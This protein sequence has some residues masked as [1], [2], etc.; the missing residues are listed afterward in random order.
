[1]SCQ[2]IISVLHLLP[3]VL[4]INHAVILTNIRMKSIEMKATVLLI[5]LLGVWAAAALPVDK[6][7]SIGGPVEEFLCDLCYWFFGEIEKLVE[8]GHT[9]AEL[10]TYLHEVSTNTKTGTH[11]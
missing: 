5:A 8:N 7:T 10:I 4:I 11:I 1:M 3:R 6:E 2:G 9:E